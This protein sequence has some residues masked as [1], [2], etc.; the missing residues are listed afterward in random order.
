[1]PR[2][3][4]LVFLLETYIWYN[5]H[6]NLL[7]GD[8]MDNFN[9]GH[10]NTDKYQ[11]RHNNYD[12]Y[13]DN[14]E[15]VSLG[16]WVGVLILLAIPIVN[17]I[18]VIAMSFMDINQNLKNFARATLILMGIGLLFGLLFGGCVA[19]INAGY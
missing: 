16:S 1:M 10:A 15:V 11:K 17:I 13:R 4:P 5:L 3:K 12:R 9:D 8:I 18:G 19:G 2:V 7:G 6:N 14:E